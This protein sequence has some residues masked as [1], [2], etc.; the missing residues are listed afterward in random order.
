MSNSEQLYK[1]YEEKMKRIADL[2]YSNAVLQWDQE[3][4]L[5]ANG[6]HFRG[7][8]IST[9]SELSHYYFSEEELGNV[10]NSLLQ[11]NDLTVEQKR[12][13]ERTHEDY[14]KNKK[15]SSEFVR[16]L[17]E[18]IHKAFHSW[19]KA[20]KENSFTIYE[21]DLGALIELKK[22]E[23]EILGYTD[24][25][26]NALLDEFEKGATVHLLDK[27]FSGIV[28]QLQSLLQ[29]ISGSPQVNNSFLHQHFPKAEQWKWGVYLIKQLH[30]NF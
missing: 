7:Q 17:S 10:L 5:P 8:Q 26:Y 18:Q 15:Y 28:P 21:H 23:T 11:V 13:V 24:H 27:S 4:Y 19:I 29:K 25:P 20:R 3:T 30:F 1:K 9:L 22:Q 14:T 12:N 6:A 16:K 2:R